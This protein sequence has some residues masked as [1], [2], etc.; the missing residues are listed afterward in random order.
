MPNFYYASIAF[1]IKQSA[2][3]S[4]ISRY[5]FSDAYQDYRLAT[6]EE[7]KHG[8]YLSKCDNQF[9]KTFTQSLNTKEVIANQQFY[10][11]SS[12]EEIATILNLSLESMNALINNPQYY[13]WR[14]AES[15]KMETQQYLSQFD[16]KLDGLK[17]TVKPIIA[18][19]L[20]FKSSYFASKFL[21][22][23]V[24]TLYDRVRN[25]RYGDNRYA[26]PKEIQ[27]KKYLPKCDD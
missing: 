20:Y 2:L 4:Q 23:Q 18:Q 11:Y 15:K 12:Y 6:K 5:K 22:I 7:I 25:P 27:L 17:S 8:Q 16:I 9:A 24:E 10:S 14:Q 19:K 21:D 1:N 13:N 3:R 26:T